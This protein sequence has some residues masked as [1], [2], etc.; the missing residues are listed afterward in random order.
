MSPFPL[1]FPLGFKHIV[2]LNAYDHLLFLVA[3]C[4]MYTIH[5]WKHLL[6]LVTSFSLGHT[7]TLS[8]C[9]FG[10]I[11]PNVHVVELLIPLTIFA[12]AFGNVAS[13]DNRRLV[14]N[15]VGF[16]YALTG[17]FGLIHGMGFS[18]YFGMLVTGETHIG[19]PLFYFTL[20]IEIGQIAIVGAILLVARLMTSIFFFKAPEW[21]LFL[22]GIAAG[23]S[24]LMAI[25][26]SAFLYVEPLT[27]TV[28]V[29]APVCVEKADGSAMVSI[30][31]GVPEYR[32]YW[33]SGHQGPTASPLAPGTY[34]VTVQDSERKVFTATANVPQPEPFSVSIVPDS[35]AVNWRYGA[36]AAVNG[37]K[38]GFNFQWSDGQ[39]DQNAQ[40]LWPGPCSL[41]VT[42]ANGCSASATTKVGR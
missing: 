5:H 11:H 36:R 18:N 42:D 6:G 14:L 10:V 29:Q 16:K 34:T 4:G 13:P 37:G 33:S 19:R 30:H 41:T 12:T 24:F 8:L 21:N 23:I 35:V 31:G 25:E 39:T 40:N 26:K 17:L 22:S 28:Q 9:A 3:L 2:D 38:A 27:A 1:Y 20:G 32:Y 15:N 7:F